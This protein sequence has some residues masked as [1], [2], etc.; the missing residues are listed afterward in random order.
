MLF[1]SAYAD[2]QQAAD[3]EA[4]DPFKHHDHRRTAQ[5]SQR[6]ADERLIDKVQKALRFVQAMAEADVKKEKAAASG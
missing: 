1:R 2:Q 5:D 6:D 3:A 4:N